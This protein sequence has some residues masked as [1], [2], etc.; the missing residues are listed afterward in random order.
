MHV[1]GAAGFAR[2]TLDRVN[3]PDV[4]PAPGQSRTDTTGRTT[5]SYASPLPPELTEFP[6]PAA[7]EGEAP[8]RPALPLLE[9]LV[10]EDIPIRAPNGI[11]VDENLARA[12]FSGNLL[13]SGTGARPLVRG[14]ITAQRGPLFL[15][16]NE[17][18]ITQVYVKFTGNGL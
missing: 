13:L 11:R 12:E 10:F 16:E 17:F 2:L 15:R 9:R 5:D 18:T 1:R 3:A 8:A 7:P 4:L 14:D 6:K